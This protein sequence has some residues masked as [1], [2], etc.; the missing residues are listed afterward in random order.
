MLQI[1][2]EEMMIPNKPILR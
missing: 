2:E 1:A